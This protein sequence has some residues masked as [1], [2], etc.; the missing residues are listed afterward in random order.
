MPAITVLM[1]VYNAEKYLKQAIESI[2]N[3]TFTDFEFLIINDCS[4]DNSLKIIRQMHD[5]DNRIRLVNNEKNLKLTSSLNKGIDLAKGKYIAR[6]D[7]DDISM[8]Q[9]LEKQYEFMERYH[10]IG[11]CGTWVQSFGLENAIAKYETKDIY[12]KLKMLHE[13]HFC[14]PSVIIRTKI[15]KQHNLYYNPNYLYSEDYEFWC[16]ALKYTKFAN[17]PEILLK[18]RKSKNSISATEYEMQKQN[19]N[20]VK[21]ILFKDLG[22][23]VTND[24]LDLYRNIAYHQYKNEKPFVVQAKNLLQRMLKA[25]ESQNIFQKNVFNNYIANMWFN[26]CTNS[27]VFGLWTYKIYYNSQ[28]NRF[29]KI[30]IKNKIKFWLKSMLKI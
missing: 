23:D 15:L 3:Q 22:I 2:L 11:I 27:T 20:K 16:R 13:S 5:V 8:P 7:A 18:Y 1:P 17:I 21:A 4:T 30:S 9:R 12:I 6:M 24:E 25:N 29:Y 14:H 26:I 10:E 19:F 28:I